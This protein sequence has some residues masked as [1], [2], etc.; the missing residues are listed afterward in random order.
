MAVP[1]EPVLFMKASTSLSGPFDP[2]VL[3]RG[4]RK[5]DWEVELA[6]I[7]GRRAKYVAESEA[8]EYV[9]GYTVMTRRFRAGIPDRAGRAV[10]EGQEL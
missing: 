10:G 1:E 4:S 3:P 6:V 9:A 7:I 2:I 8:L 5:T